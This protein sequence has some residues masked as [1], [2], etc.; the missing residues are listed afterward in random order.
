M[1]RK[2]NNILKHVEFHV[3]V[4]F[5]SLALLSWPLLGQTELGSQKKLYFILYAY[6]FICIFLLFLISTSYK[7]TKKSK[8]IIEKTPTE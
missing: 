5:F 6:W 7:D 3:L 4:F 8:T 2:I 1:P